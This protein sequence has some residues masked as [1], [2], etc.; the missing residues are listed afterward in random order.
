MDATVQEVIK[1]MVGK[2]CCRQQVG[3][4]RSLSL[5][6][7]EKIRRATAISDGVY[8]EW[9]IGTYY[10]SWRVI[11]D[12]KILCGSRDAAD[13]IEDLNVAL[14]R[15]RFGRFANLRQ[16]TDW[17]VRVELDN[18]VMIDFL[19]EVSDDDE[20]FHIFCPENRCVQ[21]SIVGGWKTGPS[22]MPWER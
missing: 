7:G 4:G 14:S 20:V 9:E 10:G 15:I 12:G 21:F 11:H 3:R 1:D 2:P 16:L 5:G 6:F 19:A 8:G 22:N 18:G 17:D 13:S